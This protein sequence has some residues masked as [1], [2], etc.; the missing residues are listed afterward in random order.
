MTDV[1]PI[2]RALV[3]VYD[4][5][6]LPELARALGEAGVEIVSTGSTAQ[7]IRDAG[8]DVVEVNEKTGFPEIMDGRVKTL[9]PKVHGGIL[10]DRSKDA[11]LAAMAD[12]G[13][14]AIDLVVVNLYPFRDTVADPDVDPA[15]A[16][17]MI[18]IGGPTMVRAAAKNHAHVAV[19]TTAPYDDLIA[20]IRE[21]TGGRPSSSAVAWP[22]RRSPTPPPT[23]PTSGTG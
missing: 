8:V 5:T 21:H 9:H 14:E 13:I 23:T 7:V 16:I 11:H 3:S 22:S 20:T 19:A 6:G 15:Q 10:A 4:K 17:E 12:H 2:R 18:D 1:Q